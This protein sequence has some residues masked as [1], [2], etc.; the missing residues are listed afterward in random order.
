MARARGVLLFTC[1]LAATAQ[2][3]PAPLPRPRRG[4]E[5]LLSVEG[6]KALLMQQCG[7][8]ALESRAGSRANEWLV[9]GERRLKL[10]TNMQRIE[11]VTHKVYSVTVVRLE[12]GELRLRWYVLTHLRSESIED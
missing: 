6:V 9:T 2:A 12:D 5:L 7:V 3:A 10:Q 8:W 4:P 1:L 11:T